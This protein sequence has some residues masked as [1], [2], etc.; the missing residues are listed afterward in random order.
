MTFWFREDLLFMILSYC[1]IMR[2]SHSSGRYMLL[3]FESDECFSMIYLI[4]P[5]SLVVAPAAP[6]NTPPIFSAAFELF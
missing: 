6:A 3:D 4:L 1:F 2:L 5:F